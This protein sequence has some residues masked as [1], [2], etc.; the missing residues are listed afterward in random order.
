IVNKQFELTVIVANEKEFNTKLIEVETNEQYTLH[1][2]DSAVGNFVGKI[3]DEYDKIINDIIQNCCD[4]DVFKSN[5]TLELIDYINKKYGD[6]LEYLWEKFPNNAIVR[7]KDNSKWYA[8]FLTVPKEKL[9]LDSKTVV[10]IIDLRAENVERNIDNKNVFAG[11]HMNK[12]HWI[13][14]ILDGSVS[15]QII[16]VKIDKSYTLA[17]T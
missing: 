11:Y 16:K 1:L 12:K 13:T 14:I 7:R 17:K 2:L 10:E 4:R 5:I 8:A 9:G 6:K 3:K 15:S